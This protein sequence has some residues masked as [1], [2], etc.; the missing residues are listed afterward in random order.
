M[1]KERYR[2]MLEDRLFDKTRSE[3]EQFAKKHGIRFY[4]RWTHKMRT[5]IIN[6]MVQRKFSGLA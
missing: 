5:S 3:L 6:A 4:S 2:E 1:T